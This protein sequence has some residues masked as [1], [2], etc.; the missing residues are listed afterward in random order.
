MALAWLNPPYLAND[1]RETLNVIFAAMALENLVYQWA[2]SLTYPQVALIVSSGFLIIYFALALVSLWLTQRLL[3]FLKAGAVI[4]TSP[5]HKNQIRREILNSVVSILI[6]TVYGVATVFLAKHLILKINWTFHLW[7]TL[8]GMAV[9]VV[10]NE[11]H[12][13]FCHRLLHTRWLYSKI[14]AV[15]HRSVVPT[16]FSTFSFHWLEAVLLGSVMITGM[17]F[18]RFGILCLVFAPLVSLLMNTFGHWNFDLLP[19]GKP[20]TLLTASRWHSH[21]H[22]RV[23]GNYGFLFPHL[24][25]LFHTN[26]PSK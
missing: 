18:Y 11:V 26:L 7:P 19:E 24:D 1:G 25:I 13:Y 8:L 9:F 3:P 23:T 12:F 17:L 4:N 10:W 16:P 14:H 22:G 15:H 21:H 2:V 6:F 5:L 20:G